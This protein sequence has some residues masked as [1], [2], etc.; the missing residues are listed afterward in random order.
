MAA[1]GKIRFEVS[2]GRSIIEPLW[3]VGHLCTMEE[4]PKA[5]IGD[6]Y[7]WD[8]SV[9]PPPE[10]RNLWKEVAKGIDKNQTGEWKVLTTARSCAFVT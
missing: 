5:P 4:E 2:R 10:A 8:D 1:Q 6:P 7:V 3:L 9:E